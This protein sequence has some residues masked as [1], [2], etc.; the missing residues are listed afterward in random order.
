ME[1]KNQKKPFL[2]IIGVFILCIVSFAAGYLIRGLDKSSDE[3]LIY[4]AYHQILDNSL[5]SQQ[6]SRALS[7][8]AIR[9][10][11]STINDPY[12]ELI[13]PEAAQ[14]FTN[15]FSG[16]TGVVGLY[17]E[18]KA[19]Q[20]VIT[21]VFSNGP[22]YQ[23]GIRVGDVILEINRVKLD[24]D[25]DSSETGLMIRGLP[26]TSVHL[27]IQRGEQILDFDI[28][29]QVRDYVT[30]RM[31]P[32]DIGYISLNAFNRTAT[33]EM[34]EALEALM[35][36]KPKGLVWDLRNN[37]GGDMQAAQDILSFF[38]KNGLLFTAELTNDR[39]VQFL[40]KENAI[41]GDVPLVALI[42]KTTYSAAE[43]SAA[44]IAETG[45]GKTVGT[46]SFG[47]GV[48]QAT[49]SLQD[50]TLLQMTIAKWLSPS[51]KWYQELGVSPQIT[52]FDDPATEA[53]ELLQAAVKILLAK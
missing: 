4:A 16:Q 53:D 43:T 37:E 48:I 49:I 41:A 33:Q 2:K 32:Q 23:A 5:F 29:R 30:S 22:A 52:V 42:D 8:A 1:L 40:A 24:K 45:R 17:A 20:V 19:G 21:I 14:N 28:I 13:E 36:Q 11:I 25:V 31:L 9:G 3:G 26:G 34:K 7:F 46:N 18:N 44:A 51:G 50:N 15:T 10:M 35:A 38:I 12:A 6:S 27:K 47:K 39:T